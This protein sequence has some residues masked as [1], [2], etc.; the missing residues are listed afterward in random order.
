MQPVVCQ[1]NFSYRKQIYFKL[2]SN[3]TCATDK[4]L[5]EN[6]KL[7]EK[8]LTETNVQNRNRRFV[9][10]LDVFLWLPEDEWKMLSSGW[11]LEALK[12]SISQMLLFSSA[13]II[14]SF[15]S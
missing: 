12:S 11:L 13:F 6:S 4:N 1:V 3:P 14:P 10:T 7:L 8:S 5:T 9:F 15:R 2:A